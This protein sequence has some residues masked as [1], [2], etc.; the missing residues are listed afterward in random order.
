MLNDEVTNATDTL[1]AALPDDKTILNLAGQW[2]L[3]KKTNGVITS[4]YAT[5]DGQTSPGTTSS[6]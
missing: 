4:E 1:R 6:N 5:T 2:N 3:S